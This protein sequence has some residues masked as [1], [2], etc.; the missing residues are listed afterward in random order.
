MLMYNR[1]RSWKASELH[2]KS[3]DDLHKLWYFLLKE[4]NML[5]T[6]CRMLHAQNVRIPN[7]ERL[8][9][10]WAS[11]AFFV[12][13]VDGKYGDMRSGHFMRIHQSSEAQTFLVSNLTY[14]S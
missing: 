14:E 11:S 1:C 8:P 10:E 7:P 12:K 9:K 6:Q 2:L 5:M 3:W 13:I 4:N